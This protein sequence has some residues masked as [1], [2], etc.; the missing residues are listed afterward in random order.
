MPLLEDLDLSHNQIQRLENMDRLISLKN[1]VLSKNLLC[2]LDY[3]LLIG[4]KKLRNLEVTYNRLPVSYLDHLMEII[5]E[6][7]MLRTVSFMGNELALNKYY[8]IKLSSMHQLSHLDS[9][10]IKSYARRELRVALLDCRP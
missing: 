1:L 10:Q 5:K 8:R 6:M 4:A 9:I 3:L 7:P 2:D